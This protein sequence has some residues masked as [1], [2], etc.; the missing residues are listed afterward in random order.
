MGLAPA[1]G[2]FAPRGTSAT[3]YTRRPTTRMGVAWEFKKAFADAARD[4]QPGALQK[5]LAGTMTLRVSAARVTDLDTALQL[6][7]EFKLKLTL[8]EAQEAF[9]RAELLAS[10]KIPVFLRPVPPPATTEPEEYRL[11]T[12]TTLIRAGVQTALLPVSDQKSDSL[13]ASVAFAVRH[14][15][16]PAEALRAVT[17]TPAE[18]LGV[19]GRVGSLAAGKDADLVVLSGPPHEITSRVEKVM[20][21]GRWIHGE[22]IER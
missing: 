16:T 9:K 2:N 7:D 22:G 20:I 12:F 5:T 15:A 6:A 11:D 4:P 3:F 21:D 8:E 14:G 17:L 18:I 13:M 1:Q 19:A 10:R